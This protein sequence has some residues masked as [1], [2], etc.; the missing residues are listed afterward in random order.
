MAL[1]CGIISI[2]VSVWSFSMMNQYE[3]TFMKFVS[4]YAS[5]ESGNQ[6][7]SSNS[8]GTSLETAMELAKVMPWLC[9]GDNSGLSDAMQQACALKEKGNL[10]N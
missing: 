9:I 4:V 5:L 2:I 3:S 8:N 6:T 1:G 10:T 7:N